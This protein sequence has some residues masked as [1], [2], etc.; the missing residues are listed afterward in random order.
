MI[1]DRFVTGA[2]QVNTYF[3]YDE[4]TKSGFIVDP[5]AYCPQLTAK[6]KEDGV[7][8]KYIILTHGHGDHIGGVECHL[9]DF[10]SAKIVACAE[11]AEMLAN[12]RHNLSGE[13]CG[14][15]VSIAADIWVHDGDTLNVGDIELTFIHTPGH[16]EGGMCVYTKGYLFSGD[17]LF[18]FSVGRTDFY[19]G[20]YSALM[21]SIREKIFPLPDDTRVFPGHMGMTRL[22]D[23]KKGNPFV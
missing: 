10:P 1:V 14:R 4:K 23:E 16:T 18:R 22:E 17:T 12:P 8:I 2:I 5:G 3:A 20:D 19:G 13:V 9:R 21:T 15:P 7:D 11:E 6:A